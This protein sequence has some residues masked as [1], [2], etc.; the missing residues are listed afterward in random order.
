VAPALPWQARLQPAEL[1]RFRVWVMGSITWFH[2]TYFR[3][4]CAHRQV[5]VPASREAGR[6][7]GD[8]PGELSTRWCSYQSH[9]RPGGHKFR[10]G[11]PQG[12]EGR[13]LQLLGYRGAVRS[14]FC[15]PHGHQIYIVVLLYIAFV[16][17]HIRFVLCTHM[18]GAPHSSL[19]VG[20]C[21]L[22]LSMPIVGNSLTVCLLGQLD[23]LLVAGLH[24][25]E[26]RTLQV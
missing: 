1:L 15:Q 6:Q 19:A 7:V 14:C 9:Q 11:R 8:N 2:V 5:A 26:L 17:M 23:G 13:T 22:Y 25:Y 12:W 10:M 16:Q 3:V 21:L 4:T 18:F 20:L 24:V